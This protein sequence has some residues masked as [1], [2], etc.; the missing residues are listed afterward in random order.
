MNNNKL[1]HTT[2]NEY[3]AW[4]EQTTDPASRLNK[5]AREYLE[6]E[7]QEFASEKPE[8]PFLSV[9]TR[10]QGKRPEMLR[11]TLLCLAGQ[12]DPDFE[13]LIIGH[14]LTD[15][16]RVSVTEIIDEQPEYMRL[17]TRLIEVRGGTRTTPL[18]KGFEAARGEYIAT[19]DDDDLVLDHWVSTFHDLSEKSPGTILH[20]YCIRQDWE[21]LGGKHPDTPR[22]A[23]APD[24]KYCFDF[25]YY[26]QLS[27]NM[28]PLISLAFP[29]YVFHELGIRFDETLT[30]AED[31]DYLMRCSFLTGVSNAKEPTQIYRCWLNAENSATTH[32]RKEWDDNYSKIVAKYV[33]SPIVMPSSSLHGVI[34]TVLTLSDA[35][36]KRSEISVL[37]DDGKGFSE[38]SK[39]LPAPPTE[40]Y[41][42][43]FIPAENGTASFAAR[44]L[45]IDLNPFVYVM[46]SDLSVRVVEASGDISDYTVS[47]VTSN[48]YCP[49]DKRIIF[50]RGDPQMTLSLGSEKQ[51]SK[52]LINC[53]F[54]KIRSND[55][56][57]LST[58][59]GMKFYYDVGS[60][61]SEDL[62]LKRDFSFR[63]RQMFDACF[64]SKDG[65]V[66][67]GVTKLR[68]DPQFAGLITL[69]DFSIRVEEEGGA[70][71][72]YTPNDVTSNG[73]LID[74][75][76]F[77]FMKSDPQIILSFPEPKNITRVFVKSTVEKKIS[78]Q[79][80]D[81]V[82]I[83]YAKDSGAFYMKRSIPYRILRKIYRK[84]KKIFRRKQST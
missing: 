57:P 60:G 79:D 17:K 33:L 35:D 19:L 61:Y 4:L 49:D 43:C 67:P 81:Y 68:F 20:A 76:R 11:E 70:S 14:N 69:T 2:V 77:V 74:D 53:S 50:W 62:L 28:C 71:T 38:S 1:R 8:R 46:V 25:S 58:I 82:S 16:Q 6:A 78:D 12:D 18:N 31:W 83:K 44:Q 5:T 66:L 65:G 42:Y 75:E 45:R 54:G 9:I 84:C 47:E 22:A 10:T 63:N 72:D 23:G 51:I 24:P 34:D 30:T 56:D 7:R 13:L 59:D 39:L 36:Y 64:V 80:V 21:T 26:K 15:A 55:D 41:D 3:F 40:E 32:S 52:V 73:C 27:V 48:G 29:S 37:Y